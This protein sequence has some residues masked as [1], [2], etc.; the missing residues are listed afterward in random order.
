MSNLQF[1]FKF[2]CM[3]NDILSLFIF[4]VLTSCTNKADKNIQANVNAIENLENQSIEP[5][6]QNAYIFPYKL[7]AKSNQ[8]V[9]TTEL[10]EISGLA[11]N[12]HGEL[13]ALNDEQAIAF[14]YDFESCKITS[15]VKFGSVGDFEGIELVQDT[16]LFAVKSNGNI[17]HSKKD[18]SEFREM[19][20]TP[21]SQT[22]D[23]EGLGYNPER[24]I[25]L[26]ACKGSP[27]FHKHGRLKKAK[28]VFSFSLEKN[29]LNELPLLVIYDEALENWV[30]DHVDKG[31]FSKKKMRQ[32][33]H[34]VKDF[35]PSGIAYH[36]LDK[37]Y[38]LISSLGKLLVVVESNGNVQHVEFLDKKVYVQ[39]EGICFS[40]DGKMYISNEGK[41]SHGRILEMPYM[42]AE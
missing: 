2:L 24:N 36:P 6:P 33:T 40:P 25:L 35:S 12:S 11:I 38:Y 7:T 37:N 3:C 27:N 31:D 21:L 34:R 4:I 10:A 41:G 29:E 42:S 1:F 30:D 23:V 28:A 16:D 22:N 18:D 13:I 9:L 15:E 19:Y 20:N 32:F 26:V 14:R 39:P 17:I 8:C 5:K